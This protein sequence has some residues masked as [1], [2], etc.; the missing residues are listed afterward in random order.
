MQS[1]RQYAKLKAQIHSQVQRHSATTENAIQDTRIRTHLSDARFVPNQQLT[2]TSARE[3]SGS[4][5]SLKY[6]D[7][8]KI[9]EALPSAPEVQ[10]HSQPA[11][12]SH[13]PTQKHGAEAT[14]VLTGIDVRRRTTR[15]GGGAD[16]VFVVGFNCDADELN[17]R[18]WPLR[19]RALAMYRCPAITAPSPEG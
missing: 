12:R 17:P 1:F 3:S 6:E 7:I 15:E 9:A 8:E 14:R 5:Q 2:Q 11:S 18:N 4:L 10:G 16:Q 19:R 13:V